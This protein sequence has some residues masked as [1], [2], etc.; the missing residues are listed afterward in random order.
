MSNSTCY[1]KINKIPVP[2][3]VPVSSPSTSHSSSP[4]PA[5]TNSP[6]PAPAPAT[7]ISRAGGYR[8][9]CQ[10]EVQEKYFWTS[11]SNNKKIG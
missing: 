8:K 2:V 10:V 1:A 5:P 3:P 4:V 9:H 11:F 7:A 6:A